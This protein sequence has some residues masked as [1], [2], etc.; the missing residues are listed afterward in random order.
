VQE[1]TAQRTISHLH[2]SEHVPYVPVPVMILFQVMVEM[3]HENVDDSGGEV[4]TKTYFSLH[5][6]L[7]LSQ[8]LISFLSPIL[9]L[10]PSMGMISS[11][12]P[13]F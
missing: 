13:R 11:P 9:S 7:F 12:S 6:L 3:W 2:H 5:D 10:M 4:G 8:N 1:S